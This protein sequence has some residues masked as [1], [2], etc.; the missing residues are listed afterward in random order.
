MFLALKTQWRKEITMSGHVFWHGLIYS[1]V[2]T[3]IGL[4]GFDKSIKAIF[5]DIQLMESAALPILNRPKS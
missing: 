2:K 5:Q 3:V 1:E 4:M